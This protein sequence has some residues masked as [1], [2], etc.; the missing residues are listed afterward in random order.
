MN[1]KKFFYVNKLRT[2]LMRLHLLNIVR[3]DWKSFKEYTHLEGK[4]WDFSYLNTIFLNNSIYILVF[5]DKDKRNNS[6][7]LCIINNR[8][9]VKNQ[10]F[11]RIKIIKC[12]TG[13]QYQWFPALNIWNIFVCFA[14]V[15]R[16]NRKNAL[17]LLIF[18]FTNKICGEYEIRIVYLESAY[19]VWCK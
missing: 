6:M 8:E 16:L 11:K 12:T 4:D 1:D 10:F 9:S 15:V 17:L 14:D 13:N 2:L 7:Q 18:Y 19:T 3:F 5:Q